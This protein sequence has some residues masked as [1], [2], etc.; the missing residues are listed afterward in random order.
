MTN[1]TAKAAEA[2]PCRCGARDSS[3]DDLSLHHPAVDRSTHAGR[4]APGLADQLSAIA[5]ARQD[6]R[7]R[8]AR[9]VERM[10]QRFHVAEFPAVAAAIRNP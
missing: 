2:L 7:E 1:Y 5:R 3:V 8:C 10:A 4:S 6:E 9:E